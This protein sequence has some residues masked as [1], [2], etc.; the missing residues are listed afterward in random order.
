M[1]K[2]NKKLLS[3]LV[4]IGLG[5]TNVFS[6]KRKNEFNDQSNNKKT[7]LK[8]DLASYIIF[9][10][11][12]ELLQLLGDKAACKELQ[13][14]ASSLQES[15]KQFLNECID[16]YKILKDP[17]TYVFDKIR[18]HDKRAV[19]N[20][21]ESKN[22]WVDILIKENVLST[23][24]KEFVTS[25]RLIVSAQEE[26]KK[27]EIKKKRAEEIKIRNESIKKEDAENK[28]KTYNSKPNIASIE[29]LKEAP[30]KRLREYQEK[31]QKD[32]ENQG[33]KE[34]IKNLQDQIN[35]FN[36]VIQA[37]K[38]GSINQ[39]PALSQMIE[40]LDRRYG[41]GLLCGYYAAFFGHI[42]LTY[43]NDLERLNDRSLF[44]KSI[45]GNDFSKISSDL[46]ADEIKKLINDKKL[47]D[48]ILVGTGHTQDNIYDK[49]VEQKIED[50]KKGIIKK[51]AFVVNTQ[52]NHWICIV[53]ENYKGA[54]ALTI[55]DSL[56]QDRR[57]QVSGY[58]N[59]LNIPQGPGIFETIFDYG[60]K[61]PVN[62]V[63]DTY[64]EFQR[65]AEEKRKEEEMRKAQEKR[66]QEYFANLKTM[67][68]AL[69][70]A[71]KILGL[72]KHSEQDEA[73]AKKASI[74]LAKKYHP[75]RND[76]CKEAEKKFCLIRSA[77]DFIKDTNNAYD[78]TSKAEEMD[79]VLDFI[80]ENKK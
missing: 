63:K 35:N 50:L 58:Y 32:P 3:L 72:N 60:F 73:Y 27:E 79:F 42:V 78:F 13:T 9:R 67:P 21:L 39:L 43:G 44:E 45:F 71:Y 18:K 55:A 26:K 22:K 51:L 33:Y 80:K 65:K 1:N 25:C 2:Y 46:H 47:G 4:L 53:A 48:N 10:N 64:K 62:F 15:D 56:G 36:I 76:G 19:L 12:H 28:K 40:G 31:L 16:E 14:M 69:V 5:S 77:Y 20:L 61:K 30:Q 52:G 38:N 66:K 68:K 37:L 41:K 17:Y 49:M 54:L 75:D 59:Q 57:L 74:K 6:M 70:L 29:K 34:S 7:K 11:K 24:Q 23:K 8:Q